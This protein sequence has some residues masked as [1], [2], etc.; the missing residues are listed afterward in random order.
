MLGGQS[1]A[2]VAYDQRGFWIQNSWGDD[3]GH[4]GFAHVYYDDWLENATDVWVA[5]L[6]VSVELRTAESTATVRSVAAGASEGY[7]FRD[8][9]PH[10][11]NLGNDGR[12][13]PNG[14]YGTTEVDV[15]SIF[16]NDLPRFTKSW[17]KKRI[18]LYAHGGLVGENTAIQRL[19]DYRAPLLE[20]QVY[21]IGFVWH[22][23][24]WSTLTNM[25]E[26][27]V[28]QR[29]P[30]GILDAAKDFMLD[31]L[32]DALEPILRNLLTKVAWDQMKENAVLATASRNGG[33]RL[34]LTHLARLA[35]QDKSVEIHVAG[36]SA[37]SIF[38]GPVVDLLTSKGAITG[39]PLDGARGFG[40]PV[41]SCSLWAPAFTV[42][43]FKRHYLVAARSRA[44]E[45]FAFFTLTDE[46]EQDDHCARIYNKSL[47][48]LVPNALEAKPRIPMFRDGEPILGMEKWVRKDPRVLA[49]CEGKDR[50]ADWA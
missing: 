3:W 8:L 27:A 24:F 22:T 48:Y 21:P 46:A 14:T 41:K 39:G 12:L 30:E 15:A 28:R 33:A 49:P 45:R 10:I 26:D 43:C 29:R 38:H 4:R 1:F 44:L 37:G 47:L 6:G 7:S 2:I 5:R 11:I 31:R 20:A 9:R 50:V 42:D 32:D 36:H 25:L 16:D 35:R 23:D 34:A 13:R 40:I 18:L 17:K 19:A